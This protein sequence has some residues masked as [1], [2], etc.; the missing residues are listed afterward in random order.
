[1]A[2]TAQFKYTEVKVIENIHIKLKIT[3]DLFISISSSYP[4]INCYGM[5]LSYFHILLF[6]DYSMVITSWPTC[7]LRYVTLRC[8]AMYYYL[9]GMNETD[10]VFVL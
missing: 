8:C 4:L 2:M 10:V 1:M 6:Y 7:S 3:T 5:Q 9:N